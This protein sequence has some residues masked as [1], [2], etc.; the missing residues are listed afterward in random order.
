MIKEAEED[1]Q[2][3][4]PEDVVASGGALSVVQGWLGI[5]NAAEVLAST[6]EELSGDLDKPRPAR[7]GLGAKFLAHNKAVALTGGVEKKLAR[8]ITKNMHQQKAQEPWLQKK[9]TM[10]ST[11]SDDSD[12]SED[13]NMSRARMVPGKKTAAG[14][15]LQLPD[16]SKRPLGQQQQEQQQKTKKKHKKN[17]KGS[18]GQPMTLS[19]SVHLGGKGL[20]GWPP[21]APS[22]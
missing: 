22:S 7:L 4:A 9:R 11:Y 1:A 15:P 20:L 2:D 17:K 14:A 5:S 3:V 21:A 8:K 6:K 13:R 18:L 16:N 10:G 12:D 19:Q